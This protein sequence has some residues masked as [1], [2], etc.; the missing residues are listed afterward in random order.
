MQMAP[1]REPCGRATRAKRVGTYVGIDGFR[2]GWI[3]VYLDDH[4]DRNF[5]YSASLEH[6]LSLPYDRALIDLP[7]G[8]PDRG[9]REC[10]LQA[11]RLVGPRVFLGA[12]WGVWEFKRFKD[13]NRHYW[14]IGDPGIS[15]QLWCLRSKLEEVNTSMTV[16]RQAKLQETHP[17][18]VFRRLAGRILDS[19]K[20]ENGRRQ[21]IHLLRKHGI[22][23]INQWLQM[24]H[25]TSIGRDD[26]MDACACALAARS[27]N[28]RLPDTGKVPTDSRGIRM[29][30]WY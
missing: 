26:L 1:K 27:S 23:E 3:A 22:A 2:K 19:K 4:G 29:E 11:R 14:K 7:I 5:D 28:L 6:L 12:R 13:V 18:L 24:R 15:Q 21:R 8:L 30:I 9:Y 20:N 17:E 10:D 16:T 25:G